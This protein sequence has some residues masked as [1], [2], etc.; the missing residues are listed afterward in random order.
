MICIGIRLTG[1]EGRALMFKGKATL[2][3]CKKYNATEK[4]TLPSKVDFFS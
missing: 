2:T 1:M 4:V 3:F